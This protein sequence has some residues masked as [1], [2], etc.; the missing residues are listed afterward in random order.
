M[1]KNFVNKYRNM[2]RTF[3]KKNHQKTARLEQK[4]KSTNIVRMTK[5][6]HLY[7]FRKKDTNKTYGGGENGDNDPD[8]LLIFAVS[9]C[10]LYGIKSK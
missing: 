6:N 8:L 7:D 4:N 5:S 1:T 10:I 2:L 3:S 9:F